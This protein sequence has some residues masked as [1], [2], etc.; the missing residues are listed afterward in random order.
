MAWLAFLAA[1]A[2]I[3]LAGTRLSRYGD[4]I[5]ARTG[6]GGALIGLVLLATVTSL[7]ELVVSATSTAAIGSPDLALGGL[8]GS[9][10]FN[11]AIIVLL[12]ILYRQGPLLARVH[13]GHLLSAGLGV[14]F[15]GIVSALIL[16][17]EHGGHFEIAGIGLSSFVFVAVYVLSARLIF[18]TERR[19]RRAATEARTEDLP[20]SSSRLVYAKTA[21]AAGLIVIAGIWLAKTGETIAVQTGWGE[22]FVGNLLLAAATSL[23]EAVVSIGALRLGA[24]DMAISNL[25]GSNLFNMVIIAVCD[26]LYRKGPI[27]AEVSPTGIM[28]GL[29]AMA[30]TGVVIAALVVREDKKST[31][32]IGSEAAA[33]LVIY[34]LGNYFVFVMSRG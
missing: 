8:L 26:A 13:P 12:D 29:T 30:M 7:P 24:V 33:L 11:L 5:A 27:L 4:E 21:A 6:L 18:V 9:N 17:Y 23:P 34:L 31:W 10:T 16:F 2:L 32:R 20:A 22:S 28:A 3:V 1:A 14:V 19:R 15:I 25:L